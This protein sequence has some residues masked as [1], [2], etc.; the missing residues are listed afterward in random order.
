MENETL[1]KLTEAITNLHASTSA[2]NVQNQSAAVSAVAVKLPEFW[3]EDPEV[4]FY[5][6]EAQL[7]SRSITQ[8]Q[9]KFDY[10]VASLDNTTAAEIKTVLLNPPAEGKYNALK[11]A[12]L[13]AFGKSQAQKDAELLNISGLGDRSPTALL[14]KIESLNNNADTLRRAFFLAQ[15][16]THVRSILALEEF[17]DIHDLAKAAD[18]IIEAQNIHARTVAASYTS[19][20]TPR[21]RKNKTVTSKP[22]SKTYICHYHKRFGPEARYCQPGCLFAELLSSQHTSNQQENFVAGRH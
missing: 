4:W 16:P 12:L 5:R 9:T 2:I 11:I 1:T 22:T 18:R 13:N 8:D 19:P 6:V 17:L 3:V 15:L 7:R 10:V 21:F 20:K 14:R